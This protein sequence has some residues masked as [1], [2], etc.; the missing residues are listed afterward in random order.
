MVLR[1]LNPIS[2]Y[3]IHA[4]CGNDFINTIVFLITKINMIILDAHVGFFYMEWK[5]KKLLIFH[6]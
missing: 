6:V 2:R 3:F 5:S 4:S 1:V